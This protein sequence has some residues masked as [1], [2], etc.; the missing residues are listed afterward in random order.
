MAR[1][2]G[3]ARALK[4]DRAGFVWDPRLASHVYRDDHPLKPRRLI[5]V[6]DTLESVG[7][8]RLPNAVVLAPREATIAEIE[9]IHSPEYV[10]AVEQA[11]AEPR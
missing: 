2:H 3:D 10:H 7:A 6:H 5:G 9:R 1:A 11:S 8:F 4:T